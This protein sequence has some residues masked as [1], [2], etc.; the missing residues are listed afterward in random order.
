MV[1][2][3]ACYLAMLTISASA[4]INVGGKKLLLID[5]MGTSQVKSNILLTFDFKVYRQ[6]NYM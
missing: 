4:H 6:I 5:C 3:F 1:G 2:G